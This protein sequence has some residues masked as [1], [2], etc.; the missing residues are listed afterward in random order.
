MNL[1]E[2]F[3]IQAFQRQEEDKEEKQKVEWLEEEGEMAQGEER[4]W[5]IVARK[6]Q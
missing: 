3:P 5:K 6:Q 2:S 1:I 4:L